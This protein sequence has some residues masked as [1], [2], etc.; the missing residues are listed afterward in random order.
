MVGFN[1]R[2]A[3]HVVKMK[4]LLKSI[5]EPKS[6]IVT[7]NAGPVASDHWTQDPEIG[8]GRIIGEGCHFIDLLRYL[9]GSK[10]VDV[11]SVQM[12]TADGTSR[13]PDRM[14]F[15]LKFEDGSFGT[16]HYLANGNR[17]FP[18]ERVEVFCGGRIL[19]LDNFRKLKGY[20]WQGF[21]RMSLWSQEKGHGSCVEA[22]VDA[23]RSNSSSPIPFEQLVE[24]TRTSFD[25]VRK[26][27]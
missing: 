5:P 22:F 23:A 7:V 6:V 26:A 12:G 1:R 14:T 15:T 19:H 21:S 2:F 25:V 20:G 8:G 17:R 24:V 27:R 11:Q 13:F 9:T 4:D 3:P 10:I 18:K 16:V